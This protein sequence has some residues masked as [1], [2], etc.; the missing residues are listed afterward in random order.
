MSK[1]TIARAT[2]ALGLTVRGGLWNDWEDMP[3]RSEMRL[4]RLIVGLSALLVPVIL[5]LS[6]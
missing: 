1:R 4:L 5:G 6:N 3:T 2:D